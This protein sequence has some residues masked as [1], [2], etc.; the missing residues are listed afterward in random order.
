MDSRPLSSR[1]KDETD[2]KKVGKNAG[3]YSLHSRARRFVYY[4]C[5]SRSL[6]FSAALNCHTPPYRDPRRNFLEY[7][8]LI[9]IRRYGEGDNDG[10]HRAICKFLLIL[11]VGGLGFNFNKYSF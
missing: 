5:V 10:T 9:C 11:E 6:L 1:N 7:R 2:G 4:H 8:L 3:K